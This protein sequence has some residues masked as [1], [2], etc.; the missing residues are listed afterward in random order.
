VNYT[1]LIPSIRPDLPSSRDLPEVGEWD[2]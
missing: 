1:V 2:L